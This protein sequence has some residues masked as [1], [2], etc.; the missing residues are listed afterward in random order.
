MS[1]FH[2]LPVRTV[3][4][5]RRLPPAPTVIDRDHPAP[6][7]INT[8][9]DFLKL[10]NF[11]T[12]GTVP[13]QMTAQWGALT[14]RAL[15]AVSL[16]STAEARER[17]IIEFLALPTRFLPANVKATRIVRHLQEGLPFNVNVA[18]STRQREDDADE[19][20]HR[21]KE[22]VHRLAM[23]RKMKSANK[24]ISIG[25][26]G[27]V[28]FKE[29]VAGLKAKLVPRDEDDAAEASFPQG[30]GHFPFQN[31]KCCHST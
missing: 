1:I 2:P 31:R 28:P 22:A 13:P 7:E 11:K 15:R 3:T 6:L 27:D 30:V 16:A 17:A 21:L 18:N 24:L 10:R 25:T 20:V 5:S 23:D 12:R 14:A 9:D 8:V 29:K 26:E 4:I 19:K